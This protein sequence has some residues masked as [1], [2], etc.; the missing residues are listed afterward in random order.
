MQYRLSRHAEEQ[1]LVRGIARAEVDA[2]LKNPGQ[3][4]ASEGRWVYQSQATVSGRPFLIRAIVDEN[5]EPFLA[6]TVYRTTKI[7]QYWVER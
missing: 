7:A 6:V 2:V 1:M 3:R 5:G 4:I